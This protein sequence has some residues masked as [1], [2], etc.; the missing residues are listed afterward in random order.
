MIQN[1]FEHCGLIWISGCQNVPPT[2]HHSIY[3]DPNERLQVVTKLVLKSE[4]VLDAQFVESL[5]DQRSQQATRHEER[6]SLDKYTN[7][8]LRRLVWTLT[9]CSPLSIF[10]LLN[11][12]IVVIGIGGLD[13]LFTDGRE[14]EVRNKPSWFFRVRAEE[15]IA[16][17]NIPV[18]HPELTEGIETLG[19]V[20]VWNGREDCLHTFCSTLG[21]AQ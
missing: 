19:D 11:N 21:C 15:N 1:V 13:C 2:D 5:I 18:I 10:Q 3:N 17:A 4:V 8:G 7:E 20:S 16:D 12:R 6:S 9:Y 14:V